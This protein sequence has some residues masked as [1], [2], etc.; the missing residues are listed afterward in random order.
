MASEQHPADSTPQ[1]KR[2]ECSVKN[3]PWGEDHWRSVHSFTRGQAKADYW[4]DVREPWPDIPFTAVRV[5][6]PF[7]ACDTEQFRHTAEYRKVPYHIGDL[8]GWR[9]KV[10]RIVNSNSSANFEVLFPDG[11]RIH[12]HPTDVAQGAISL[13]EP[14]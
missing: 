4:R 3:A 6:G 1:I 14:A 8:V 9:G 10:G 13:G 5:R 12:I 11:E 7:T 2:F